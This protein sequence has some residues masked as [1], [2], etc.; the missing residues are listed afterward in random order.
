VPA[1]ERWVAPPACAWGARGGMMEIV[2]L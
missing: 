2:I 1:E